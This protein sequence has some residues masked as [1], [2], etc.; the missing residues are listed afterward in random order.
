[1]SSACVP[2][3]HTSVA[4]N[5]SIWN[6]KLSP[7]P[8]VG[9]ATTLQAVPFQC[10]TSVWAAEVPPYAP[11]AHTLLAETTLTLYRRLSLVPALGL[12]TALQAVPF[13]CSM[14]V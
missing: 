14:S 9:L 10:S 5:R 13:Q 3:A 2:A 8:Q 6:M 7:V 1:M 11:T 4:G 12:E